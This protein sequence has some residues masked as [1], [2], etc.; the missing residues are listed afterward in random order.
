MRTFGD[1]LGRNLMLMVALVA[2]TAMVNTSQVQAGQAGCYIVPALDVQTGEIVECSFCEG[3][4]Q[5][6]E[7]VCS[8]SCE[9]GEHGSCQSG[10]ELLNNASDLG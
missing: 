10:S 2:A 3:T 4:N 1:G 7:E 8:W 5:Q 9:N 6:G